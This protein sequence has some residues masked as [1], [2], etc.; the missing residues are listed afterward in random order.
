MTLSS[1]RL[2]YVHRCSIL[3]PSPDVDGYGDRTGP[4]WVTS[5]ANIACRAWVTGS[6]EAANDDRTV[7][8]EDRRISVPLSVTVTGSDRVDEVKDKHGTIIFDGPM[9]VKGV[10]RH[11]DHVEL[12]VSRV[13]R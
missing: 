11:T 9:E 13:R 3:T 7:I 2:G 6:V 10:L 4:D 12:M 1:T 5:A 8:L